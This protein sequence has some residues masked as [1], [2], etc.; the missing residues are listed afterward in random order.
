MKHRRMGGSSR[1]QTPDQGNEWD[2][3]WGGR[4][5]VPGRRNGGRRVPRCRNGGGVDFGKRLNKVINVNKI[6]D[7]LGCVL[8]SGT[9]LCQV[10]LVPRT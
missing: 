10:A 8:I 1:G 6:I 9:L 5:G 2:P 3:I 4:W 7:T